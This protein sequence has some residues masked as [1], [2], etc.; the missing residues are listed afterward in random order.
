MHKEGQ[1]WTS[2]FVRAIC[3]VSILLNLWSTCVKFRVWGLELFLFI[4]VCLFYQVLGHVVLIVIRVHLSLNPF[5][6]DVNLKVLLSIVRIKRR[7]CQ[8]RLHV[9][10]PLLKC[11]VSYVFYLRTYLIL[12]VF[13]QC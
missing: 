9:K 12:V 3:F 10:Y 2:H 8:L 13:V 4:F 6:F 11:F 5:V 7:S 1:L